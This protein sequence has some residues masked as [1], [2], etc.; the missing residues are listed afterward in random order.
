MALGVHGEQLIIDGVGHVLE[1]DEAGYAGV[2]E[3]QVKGA[4][5]GLDPFG[6]RVDVG[7]RRCV[8]AYGDGIVPEPLGGAI[9]C[10]LGASG[11]DDLSAPFGWAAANPKRLLPPVIKVVLPR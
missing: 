4:E 8:A 7:E 3:Q 6:E 1:G 5:L 2:D 10:G 9:E 11:D